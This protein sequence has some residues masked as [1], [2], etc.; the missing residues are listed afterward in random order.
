[1]GKTK[2][3]LLEIPVNDKEIKEFFV[4]GN[5]IPILNLKYQAVLH[6]K[7]GTNYVRSAISYVTIKRPVKGR[8]KKLFSN[9]K[10]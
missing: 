6:F 1:M 8:Q 4:L 9:L 2:R 7:D 5:P 3:F 10:L